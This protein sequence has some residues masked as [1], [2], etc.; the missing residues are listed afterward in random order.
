MTQGGRKS[1]L[2]S[3]RWFLGGATGFA[4]APALITPAQANLAVTFDEGAPKDRFTFQNVGN[5]DTIDSDANGD[6][7]SDSFTVSG[8]AT[9]GNA[10]ARSRGEGAGRATHWLGFCAQQ[11]CQ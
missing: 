10:A 11:V 2:Y 3:R 7:V 1:R 9:T 6:G 8:G 4:A 5:D